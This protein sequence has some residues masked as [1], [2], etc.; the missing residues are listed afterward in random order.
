MISL[1]KSADIIVNTCMGLEN[2]ESCLI[3]TDKNKIDIAKAIFDAS[4]KITDNV[5]LIE[6]PVGR[7]NGEEPPAEVASKML[8]YD[9]IIMP[10]TKS[11]THTKA[12]SKSQKNGARIASMPG[13]TKEIMKRT[14]DVDYDTMKKLTNDLCDILDNAKKVHVKTK[15]G[16]DITL[17][18]EGK[19]SYGRDSGILIKK[20]MRGNLPEAE[21]FISMNKT[22]TN[23]VYVVDA[24]HAGIGII[25]EPIKIAVK[26]GFAV[27]IEGGYQ[28]KKLLEMLD[29][30]N[31]KNA[32]N[33]AEFG[34]G[35]N[36]KAKISG[37]TL[38]DEKVFGTCHIAFG[39]DDSFGGNVDVPIHVDGVIKSPTI[40][41]DGKVIMTD[42]VL[43]I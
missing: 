11:L 21:S 38:E 34:I 14:I 42:G 18:I 13:V 40:E 15:I 26:D 33:I 19:I 31:D 24:S 9:V 1:Q 17:N 22:G 3:I 37:V 39:K 32:Y 16:T 2:E 25:K 36:K 6:I 4:K 29:S 23:G 35:T 20:G 28:A 12:V 27:N 7:V 8:E 43:S 10:I 5:E 41:I 30:I